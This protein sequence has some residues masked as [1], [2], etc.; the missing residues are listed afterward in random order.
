[1]IAYTAE[2]AAER[3]GISVEQL[4]RL[5]GLEV[6]RPIANGRF[7]RGDVRRADLVNSLQAA[8][9]PL[10]NM[11]AEIRSKRASLD[12][13][14]TAAYERF[15]ALSAET[16][17][18]VSR[19]TGV[20]VELLMAVREA[21]GGAEPSP[22]DRVREGEL[23]VIPF[24]EIQVA[25]AFGSGAIETLLR[26]LGDCLRQMAVAEG[27][28]WGEVRRVL[29]D[30]GNS[31]QE[32]AT[33]SL[34]AQLPPLLEQAVIALY[35]SQQTYAW[36]ATVIADFE[37]RLVATGA[38]EPTVRPPAMCF[39]DLT[40]YTRLTQERGDEAAARLAG[41]LNRLTHRTSLQHGGRPVK[42][43]GDGVM[44]Y[45]REPGDGV[46]AAL[47]ML[48]GVTRAGLPPPHVG[49]HAGPVVIQGGDYFGQTVN[50]AARIADYARPNEV[51]VTQAVV[52]ASA[53]IDAAF[54]PIGPVELRGI[55]GAVHLHSAHRA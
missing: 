34:S 30:A 35:R 39:L 2:E 51:L 37:S 44:F 46:L 25:S 7:T 47:D 33:S 50:L 24:L 18:D 9:L 19:R 23:A 54:S 4:D 20:P 38:L 31:A 1:M 8:G 55:E 32:I 17:A 16:F 22:D 36:T 28:W 10:D 48:D 21:A 5:V 29:A 43:L 45:F 6:L 13:V 49:L 41:D 12:F 11:A 52:D 14:D 53:G 26:S 15:S 27:Q 42:W 3:A 40:G